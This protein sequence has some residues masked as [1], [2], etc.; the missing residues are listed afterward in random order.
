MLLAKA[1][2]GVGAIRSVTRIVLVL[3]FPLSVILSTV[4]T[5]CGRR[6]R[7]G[8]TEGGWG[9]VVAVGLLLCLVIAEQAHTPAAS[10]S[11]PEACS[12][13]EALKNGL[14]PLRPDSVLFVGVAAKPGDPF[15]AV[16]L[17]AMLA[18]QDLRIPTVNGYSGHFP[19]GYPED[20]FLLRGDVPDALERWAG[21]HGGR[22]LLDRLVR[23]GG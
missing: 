17:D 8:R 19:P 22:A 6:L 13:L 10:F 15:Y 20:L 11:V 7:E 14:P 5:S 9:A 16:Q 21:L 12:R 1:V 2:P 4:L 3:L 18:S 23:P